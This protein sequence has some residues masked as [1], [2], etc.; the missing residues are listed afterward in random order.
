VYTYCESIGTYGT[1]G[2]YGSQNI[3]VGTYGSQ[4]IT[5]GTVGTYGSY[6]SPG[7][8]RGWGRAPC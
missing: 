5:V 2:T 8:C 1:Y 3:T 4:N 7:E 6:R